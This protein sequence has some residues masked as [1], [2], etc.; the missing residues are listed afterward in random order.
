MTEGSMSSLHPSGGLEAVCS[1]GEVS[2]FSRLEV[3]FSA[4]ALAANCRPLGFAGTVCFLRGRVRMA[5]SRLWQLKSQCDRR[6]DRYLDSLSRC[7]FCLICSQTHQELVG[8]CIC[9]T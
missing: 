4:V 2:S 9:R 6:V 8:M 1:L 3:S 5:T 7:P